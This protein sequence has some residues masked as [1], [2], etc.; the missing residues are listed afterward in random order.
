MQEVVL[1][2]CF[3]NHCFLYDTEVICIMVARKSNFR[4]NVGKENKQKNVPPKFDTL[5]NAKLKNLNYEG[6]KNSGQKLRPLSQCQKEEELSNNMK[7][8]KEILLR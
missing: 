4:S 3:L 5:E 6:T 1:N 2:S 8:L 7:A